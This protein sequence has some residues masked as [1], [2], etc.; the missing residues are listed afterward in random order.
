MGRRASGGSLMLGVAFL[1]GSLLALGQGARSDMPAIA[2][3]VSLPVLD[4]NRADFP[5]TD[6]ANFSPTL[7][8][9]AGRH[10]FLFVG[11]DGHFYFQDGTRA[12]FWGINVAKDA[13]FVPHDVIDRAADAIARAGFNLVRLHHVDGI[14]GLLPPE[15][16]GTDEP[17]APA[18]LDAVFYW[19][20]ALKQRGIYAYLDLLDFRTFQEAEGV[21]E[22]QALGRGA[23]PAAVFNER[24]IELQIAYAKALLFENVNPYTSLL[25]GRDPAVAMVELCDENGLFA[26]W[27]KWGEMPEPY[28]AELQRRWNFWLRATYGSDDALR[29]A[30][31]DPDGWSGLGVDE[32]LAN[33]SVS[34]RGS[35]RPRADFPSP[36]GAPRAGVMTATRK[37]DLVR[38]CYSVHRE[39]F[40]EMK[41]ALREAGL[42]V[43]VTAVTEWEQP[44]DLRAVA[45]ELDFIGCNWYYDHPLFSPGR[46]WH[47]PSFFANTSP[48]AD[49]QGLDFTSSVLRAAVC[50]KPLVV[51]EWGACWPS[52]F[53]GVGLLEAAAY[54]ALQDIDAI[55]MFTYNAQPAVRR[56]EYFDV[57]SDPVRWGL[58]GVAGHVFRT[59]ALDVA[60]SATAVRLAEADC[61]ALEASLPA[62]LLRLG[63]VSRLRQVF[64]GESAPEGYDRVLRPSDTP[65]E[66]SDVGA[67]ASDTGQIRRLIDQERLV[68]DAPRVQA[69][70]GALTSEPM[71]TSA[72]TFSSAS[73]IGVIASLSLD[74]KPLAD[75]DV[76]LLKMVTVAANTGEQKSTRTA[77][78][79]FKLDAFGDAPVL[80]HGKPVPEPTTV[81]LSGRPLI[82]VYLENGTWE[83]VRKG[84]EW[85]VWCDT[86][87]AKFD[88]RSL[89]AQVGVVPFGAAGAKPPEQ[90][91]QPFAYPKGCL[92]VQVTAGG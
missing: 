91:K 39:Y 8:A 56:I 27:D 42:Q 64:G 77:T 7:D 22:A 5:A 46:E 62:G 66:A 81:E 89:G 6:L 79:Q 34:L 9:P 59:Q 84:G 41:R 18:K 65:A 80:T 47:V 49:E 75:T 40:A 32:S 60:R 68:L 15:R 52:K 17:L 78:P 73:P 31:Q 74:G 82:A 2:P 51:R 71:R 85:Y 69:V 11:T 90:A 76:L 10:G 35:D 72:A 29:Q 36:T 50:G 38:F 54:A 88:L 92:F 21:V 20:H 24:L 28:G 83:A 37:R 1:T 43:P 48:I 14:E 57:S 19:V 58:A 16:A 67:C 87:G 53:R 55:V 30:W 3:D 23:K 86:P 13:V 44:A 12:R 26:R 4:P 33:T 45:D 63:W 25:L 61:F 70:A